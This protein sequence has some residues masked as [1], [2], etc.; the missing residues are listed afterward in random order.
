MTQKLP[1]PV[2]L[3]LRWELITIIISLVAILLSLFSPSV[4]LL[5][6]IIIG[7]V[8][9]CLRILLKLFKGDLG[10]DSLAVIA[11]ITAVVLHQYLAGVIIVLMLASG[12]ALEAY[13]MRKASSVLLAL[14]ERMPA[15]AHRRNPNGR[16][17]DIPL[18]SIRIGDEIVIYPHETCPVDGIV[19][20]GQG[21]MDESYLTGEP[22]QISKAPGTLVL[23]GAINGES[24]L[25]LQAQKLPAES[26]YASIVSVL[27]EAEQKRPIIRRLGD[28]IGAIFAPIVLIL[29]L[30][31]WYVTGDAVRFLAV[32]V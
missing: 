22:Y 31:T 16:I 6:A 30:S 2:T 1:P 17:E 27:Q 12:Q 8:P 5:I 28:Q 4:P 24:V 21:S 26:R 15:I 3:K 14:A 10:A 7:G 29:A 18:L 25:T 32:L 19:I 11:L 9:A 23:S 13:A 20:E